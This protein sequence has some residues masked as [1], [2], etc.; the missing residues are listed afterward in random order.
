MTVNLLICDDSAD[1]AEVVSFAAGV[2][3]PTCRI[4]I[5]TNGLDALR[6][7]NES[8]PDLV[9]LDICMPEMDGFEV[10]KHIRKISQ[11]PI[12]MLTGR[13]ATSDKIKAFEIGADD[14]VTKPF[15]AL[16]LV[17][18]MKALLRRTSNGSQQESSKHTQNI[19]I[20]ELSVNTATREVRMRDVPVHLT[21]KEYNLLVEMAR[22]AGTVLS[23]DTL[24]RRVWGPEYVGEDRYVKV[25]V[26]KLRQKLG[27]DPKEPRYIQTE[28]GVGY[29]VAAQI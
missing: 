19:R 11:V 22:H 17:A 24:L 13:Q 15:D 5:A 16:E 25:F 26:N 23:H 8:A 21:S 2:V 29:K 4:N 6:L 27:D 12:I 1:L 18:R 20:G 10:C 14:F 28:W 3:W 9:V 7:F